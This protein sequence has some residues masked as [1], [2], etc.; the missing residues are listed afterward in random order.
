MVAYKLANTISE[1]GSVSRG[2]CTV[3]N[4]HLENVVE[5]TNIYSNEN[6]EIVFEEDDNVLPLDGDTAVSMNFFVLHPS[7]FRKLEDKFEEFLHE[8]AS[9]LKAEFFLPKVVN[10]MIKEDQLEVIVEKSDDNWFGMTYPEDREVVVNS[11]HNL[12]NDQKYP[13]SLWT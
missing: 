10:D 1:N 3:T 11:I 8:N 6:G 12:I 4:G 9:Q 2:V 13:N 5:R 7:I